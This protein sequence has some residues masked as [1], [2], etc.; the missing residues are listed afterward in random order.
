MSDLFGNHIVGFTTGRL[1]FMNTL[2][3]PD[4]NYTVPRD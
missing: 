4:D 1:N 2:G 3:A